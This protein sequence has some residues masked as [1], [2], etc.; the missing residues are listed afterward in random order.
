[1][2]IPQLS[3]DG[4]AVCEGLSFGSACLCTRRLGSSSRSRENMMKWV[5]VGESF[6]ID[7]ESF[8]LINNVTEQLRMINGAALQSGSGTFSRLT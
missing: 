6:R 4:G 5:I 1:M 2:G 3:A 8:T 7:L